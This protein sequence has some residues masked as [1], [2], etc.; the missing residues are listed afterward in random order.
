MLTFCRPFHPRHRGYG[1]PRLPWHDPRARRFSNARLLAA[2]ALTGLGVSGL[3][4]GLL[5]AQHVR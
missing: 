1:C 5:L 3:T 2:L 4:W